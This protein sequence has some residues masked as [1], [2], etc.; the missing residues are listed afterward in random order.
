PVNLRPRPFPLLLPLLAA[1]A[2]ALLC[3]TGSTPQRRERAVST[4]KPMHYEVAL[5]F[6]ETLTELTTARTAVTLQVL[7]ES[8]N[9]IDLD[10][11]EMP[12]DSVAV[13]NSTASIER[14]ADLL[15]VA[16]PQPAKRGDQITVTI[17]YHGKPKD[18]LSFAI[19]RDGKPSAT[20]DN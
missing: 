5:G 14:A 6:N 10:F 4:W 16:L 8:L 3:A 1:I 18:G 2:I 15:N 19:D 17:N 13:G 9:T 12:I 20:G 7:A 11:G